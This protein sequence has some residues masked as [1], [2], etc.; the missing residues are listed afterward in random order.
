VA[1]LEDLALPW[2]T[3]LPWT[4]TSN[5]SGK[6]ELPTPAEACW[7]F[8]AAKWTQLPHEKETQLVMELQR[9]LPAAVQQ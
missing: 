8:R 4:P 3:Q 6:A 1:K 9:K 7:R 2:R 5:R